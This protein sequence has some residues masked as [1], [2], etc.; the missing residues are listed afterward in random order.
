MTLQLGGYRFAHAVKQDME[1][2]EWYSDFLQAHKDG[3][4]AQAPLVVYVDFIEPEKDDAFILKLSETS[5]A[6][7]KDQNLTYSIKGDT[8]S[9]YSVFAGVSGTLPVFTKWINYVLQQFWGSSN[10]S[11][12]FFPPTPQIPTSLHDPIERIEKAAW[13]GEWLSAHGDKG[14]LNTILSRKADL[15][16]FLGYFA[17]QVPL[18]FR[19][20]N[21][22]K[23]ARIKSIGGKYKIFY[24]EREVTY[25]RQFI[26][27]SAAET[28]DEWRKVIKAK[29]IMTLPGK[30]KSGLPLLRYEE[31]IPPL[32]FPLEKKK[33]KLDL[34][35][36]D[37][38]SLRRE[39]LRLTNLITGLKQDIANIQKN[40]G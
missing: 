20:D 29:P 38:K 16:I 21:S 11:F 37:A 31:L 27:S 1:K 10:S 18:F 28:Y 12:V 39:F 24:F 25:P 17:N 36:M 13:Y 26:H 2:Q 6:G 33:T 40:L 9:H 35:D 19:L 32:T 14:S 3:T 4:V 22:I 5:D 8:V 30:P 23:K 15:D 34:T 7:F